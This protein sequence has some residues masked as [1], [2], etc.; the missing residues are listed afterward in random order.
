MGDPVVSKETRLFLGDNSCHANIQTY[1]DP[2]YPWLL[3]YAEQLRAVGNW[4]KFEIDLSKEKTNFDE[5][6]QRTRHIFESGL[7]FAIC[8]DSCAG[9]APLELFVNNGLSNCPEWELYVTNHQNNELLH[10]ESYTEMVR[11]IYNDVDVFITDIMKDEYVQKRAKTI[12]SAFD[13][14]TSV[15]DRM[16]ANNTVRQLSPDSDI[17][18]PEITEK[19]V[20]KAIYKSLMVIN[21]FE[22][23]RF[24]CTF[25]TA[26][27]FSEQPTKY[28]QGSSNIFKLIARDEMIHLDVIQKVINQLNS[29][30]DEGFK[31]VIAEM[32]DEVYDMFRTAYSEEMDWI[33]YLFDGSS[34]LIGMNESILSSYMDYIFTVR[35]RAIG[36]DSNIIGVYQDKNPLPWTK[37]YLD[38]TDVK[39][40]PQEMES[41]SYI[42]AISLDSEEEL[43]L[44]MI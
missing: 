22:G 16:A 28:M 26:W 44:D 33:K 15:F 20:K 17:P 36:L 34:P 31:E 14:A 25:A 4:S 35:M 43:D 41:V 12:L 9:R 13:D 39:T 1:H 32:E 8:L 18:Y 27:S 19:A 24:F 37:N 21:M 30:K 10:S 40:A 7:R 3:E 23:I 38:S 6:D 42:A 5:L 2:K 11:A 29:E